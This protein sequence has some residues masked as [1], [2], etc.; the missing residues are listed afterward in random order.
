MVSDGRGGAGGEEQE[1]E[2]TGEVVAADIVGLGVLDE[3]PDVGALQVLQVIVVGG[4][5]LG[6]HAAVVAGDDDA[7]AAGGD[8]GVDAVLDAQT[9]LLAGIA[10]DGGVL[11]V[12]G[13]AEVD[14]AVV[15]EDVLG[16]AGGVLGS[17]AGNQ[18][19][20]VVVEEVLVDVLVLGRGEDGVVGLEAVLLEQG[21]V[22]EGLDVWPRCVSE[23]GSRR[24][25]ICEREERWR[26]WG[27]GR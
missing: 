10:E 2:R 6:A 12:A 17:A 15:G 26:G 13:A 9:G 5:Q 27:R 18:L 8:L 1:R 25:T 23:G 14:D 3:G 24:P 11:V 22:A 16:A 20:I 19:G 4:T 7:A 21:L